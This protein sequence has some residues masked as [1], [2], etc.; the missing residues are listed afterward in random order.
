MPPVDVRGF[1]TETGWLLRRRLIRDFDGE[2][3]VSPGFARL[4]RRV[5]PEPAPCTCGD[6]RRKIKAE[7]YTDIRVSAPWSEEPGR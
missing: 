4:L 2:I 5:T 6:C 7:E 3:F 1:G